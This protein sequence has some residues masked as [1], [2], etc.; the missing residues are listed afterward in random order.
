MKLDLEKY[1]FHSTRGIEMIN[2][3][4]MCLKRLES[5]L[6]SEY[7]LSRK[8]QK[9]ILNIENKKNFSNWNGE[10]Y[11]SVCKYN[12][13]DFGIFGDAYT[14]LCYA[15]GVT[16]VL[17]KNMLNH[18]IV[19]KDGKKMLNEIQIKDKISI[20]FIKAIGFHYYDCDI[21]NVLVQKIRELLDIYNIDVP[22]IDIKNG[23]I[24]EKNAKRLTIKK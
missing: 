14:T 10:D 22:I 4:E 1:Y 16:I 7:I 20:N 21:D 5:I 2:N 12:Y 17:D 18:S 24:I 13:N 6:K 15:S 23:M 9:E 3:N 11:I 8:L 19:R